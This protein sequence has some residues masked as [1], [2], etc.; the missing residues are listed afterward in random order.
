M[1]RIELKDDEI[2]AALA[3]LSARL[4]DMTLVMQEVGELL[5]KSTKDR[6]GRG[7]APDGSKWA[8]KSP[9]TE[10]RDRRPLFG[11]SGMLSS[12]IFA[13]PGPTSVEVG[14]NR[15][16]AAMMQFGGSRAA[17]AHLWGDIPARPFL[18]V[19]E[20]DRA[21]ILDIV[22]EWIEGAAGGNRPPAKAGPHSAGPPDLAP[23]PTT[24]ALAD[25][26]ARA[27]PP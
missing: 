16:Q 25:Y 2:T 8:P 17:Y 6:F 1:I 13:I 9:V 24:Q 10:G 11:P 5:M 18:G 14:S 26:G 7:E 3:A 21:G 19:S 20:T 12:Q 22:A 4:T 23:A 15:V 27:V